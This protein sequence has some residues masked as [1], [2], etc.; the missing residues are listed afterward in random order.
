MYRLPE[1]L[2]QALARAAC[3]VTADPRQAFAVRI[4]W[5]E[6]QRAHGL[7][8][9]PTPDVLP[10][11]SWL[12]RSWA[13]AVAE[14]QDSRLGT[15]LTPAQERTLWEQAVTT[16]SGEGEFLHPHGAARAAMRSWQR[17]HEWAI[18]RRALETAASEETRTFLA[19]AAHASK[20]MR[21]HEWI[22]ASRALWRCPVGDGANEATELMLLGFDVEPPAIR[23][24]LARF[25]ASGVTARHTP[26]RTALTT[27]TKVGAANP[28]AE[29]HA[30][31]CWARRRLERNPADRLLI[32]IPDL[33]E[34]R[35]SVEYMFADVLA[36]ASLLTAPTAAGGWF[37]LEGHTT[38]DSY[39]IVATALTSL[40]LA[41]GRLAYD[42][43]SHWLRAPYLLM[44]VS[45]AAAR[46]RLDLWLRRVA[47]EALDLPN[48]ISS[49]L[50]ADRNGEH[51]RFTSALGTFAESLGTR[52]RMPGEWSAAFSHALRVLG[53]PGERPLDSAEHQSV[54]KFHAALLEL[55]TL[56]RLVG[57]LD[58]AAAA[59]RLRRLLEQTAF[60]PE[61]GDTP[62][63]ITSR[64]VDPVLRYDGIWV[65]G[66]HAGAWPEAPRADPFIPWAV[67][68]AAGLPEASAAGT[69]ALAHGTLEAWTACSSE[70]ILTWPR[71]LDDEDC[72]ASPLLAALPD[73]AEQLV[74][75]AVRPYASVIRESARLERLID[76][77]APS[78]RVTGRHVADARTLTLQSWCPI[79]AFA[80]KRLGAT[81]LEQPQPGIDV[82]TRGEFLHRVLEKLWSALES[83][84]RLQQLSPHE[85]ETLLDAVLGAARHE[86]LERARRWSRA[87]M[88]LESERLRA[89]LQVWLKIEGRR[90]SFRIAAV[91]QKLDLQLAGVPFSLRIDRI[92]ELGDGRRLLID[93]KSGQASPRRWYGDR[94]DDPQIPLYATAVEQAPAA[95]AYALLNA[96]G[97]R[98]EG[99]STAPVAI[100]GLEEVAD[101]PRLL[102]DWRAVIERLASEFAGGHAAV[103]PKREACATCHLHSFC[104][105]DEL[106]ARTAADDD[107]E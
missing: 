66:L 6:R 65:C 80:E 101:W 12:A 3:I 37:A 10:L 27:A 107:D 33:R 97:C 1:Y 79:R 63:T 24:L 93:Y 98:F 19:W 82:R 86:V 88:K 48:L 77:T 72:D 17:M 59:R 52:P 55:A 87:T 57:P 95:L 76:E 31:A 42:V 69:L 61:T 81:V 14:G 40:E 30:A 16:V 70:V 67:Q 2:E 46:A 94:P 47:A 20:R 53:W 89:L 85:R 73:A 84:E 74:L 28:E 29:I 45:N 7:A 13:R 105:I 41:A 64:L 99:V 58:L 18:D 102:I 21:D 51:G 60:Q 39:A 35:G 26:K 71:R 43:V 83:S 100:D 106:R 90:A 91:E 49:L 34:R 25:T 54:E 22:D 11:S 38:L 36:P 68:R 8:V 32:A 4:A 78:L 92:D 96:A 23:E 104:R 5:G 15:L 9:W 103:D 62:I 56:D 75:P 50:R 44:G